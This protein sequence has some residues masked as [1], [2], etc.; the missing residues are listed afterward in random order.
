MST[1]LTSKTN[2]TFE[3][4]AQFRY[5]L[6]ERLE[7]A[8]EWYEDELTSAI[9]PVLQGLER[10]DG[11]RKIRWEFGVLFRLNNTT[12]DNTY[13]FNLEFEF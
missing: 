1:V 9:G 5:R 6:S 8:I 7:P 2:S 10:L 3:A 4:A 13:R 12:P 11:N